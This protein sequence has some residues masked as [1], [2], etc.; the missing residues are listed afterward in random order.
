MSSHELPSRLPVQRASSPSR[1][2]VD[3]RVA[4]LATRQH[5]VISLAQL[6]GC[7]LSEDA[8]QHRER[9]GRLHRLHRGVYAVGHDG[10]GFEGRAMA[11]VLAM[12]PGARVSHYSAG[13]LLDIL[14]AGS[15]SH[16]G[17]APIDVTVAGGRTVRDRRGVARHRSRSDDARDLRWLGSLPV[18]SGART[19]L[20]VAGVDGP[21]NA[22]RMMASA[23]RAR[24]TTEPEVRGLLTRSGGHP[25]AGVVA[26]LLHSGPAFDRSLAE[27][28]LLELVRR[29]GLPEPRMNARAGGFEVD[30]LWSRERCVVE[31]DS[32]TFHG[33]RI[34]FR[35]DR[36]KSAR[37]QAAGYDV[38]PVVWEDLLHAPETVV[39]AIAGVLAIARS[40]L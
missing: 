13:R 10:V 1:S 37:L 30:G 39:A 17:L 11:A 6:R 18:T 27:R 33:D 15:S 3:H 36:R 7:G 24:L 19:V 20:D 14:P 5:G 28:H 2:S 9:R 40:R 12:G 21:R 16:L 26:A 38:V 35:R 29:A 8:V 32:F 23:L 4:V 25:G 22:E 34:A 31:F